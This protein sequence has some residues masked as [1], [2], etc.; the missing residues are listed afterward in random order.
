[1][2]RGFAPWPHY[3]AVA[4][5]VANDLEQLQALSEVKIT[6][7]TGEL[8]IQPSPPSLEV[9]TPSAAA[10]PE[11][12]APPAPA[13]APAVPQDHWYCAWEKEDLVGI[14]G[15]V[16]NFARYVT[17]QEL[18]PPRAS[19]YSAI[20]GSGKSF[21][22]R[23]LRSEIALYAD[24]SRT[25]RKVG[26]NTVFCGHVVQIEFNAWH[27]VESNLW[28]SVAGYVFEQLYFELSKARRRTPARTSSM[29]F[30]CR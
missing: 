21:F 18:V 7:P 22:L 20:W 6:P 3:E 1:M 11:P 9:D 16:S 2:S 25:A 8:K 5:Q 12:A 26:Q 13:P 30:S 27:Y 19:V 23:A 14:R 15:H 24:Q 28:A 17:H 4:E 10:M 29:R